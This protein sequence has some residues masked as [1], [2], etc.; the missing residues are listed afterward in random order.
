MQVCTSLQ[1]DNHASN[2]HHSGCP[3]F[4]PTNGVKALKVEWSQMAEVQTSQHS[5]ANEPG[6]MTILVKHHQLMNSLEAFT[7]HIQSC[8]TYNTMD[9]HFYSPAML[10]IY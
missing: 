9:D 4:H 1:T 3:A 10:I 7:E 6:P 2:P 8:T 5:A